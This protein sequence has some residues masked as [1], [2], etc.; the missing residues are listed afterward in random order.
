MV[1]RPLV[2]MPS[3]TGRKPSICSFEFDDLDDD[4]QI[5]RQPQD[6]GGV[7]AAGM[8]EADVSAQDGRA[9][10]MHFA[11]FE[12]DRLVQRQML[13]PVVFTEE[14]S[15]Q[16]G[17]A[18]NLHAQAPFIMLRDAASTKPAQ[19]PIRHSTTDSTTLPPARKNSPSFM[20]L[21]V[22]RL[23]DENVV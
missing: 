13:K 16:H 7:N 9:A 17:I 20:R 18:W 12:D 4:R 11:G 1:T 2:I 21:S 6:L 19:T 10:E 23:N 3:S 5:L 8:T 22:C 14:D 15:E